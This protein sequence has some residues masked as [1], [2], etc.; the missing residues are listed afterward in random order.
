M[1]ILKGA[2]VLIVPLL[3][4]ATFLTWTFYFSR[5]QA[6]TRLLFSNEE[7]VVDQQLKNI[8]TDIRMIT[9][10]LKFL[11]SNLHLKL[12]VPNKPIENNSHLA[13][14]KQEFL[15]FSRA[16]RF[17]DQIRFLDDSGMETVRINFNA[18]EKE[19]MS[20]N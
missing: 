3:V 8:S 4:I 13:M 6:S 15:Q 9:T 12:L 18:G 14:V 16:K 19:T 11:S 5:T 7:R 10:D 17:Y 1:T 20:S 2:L